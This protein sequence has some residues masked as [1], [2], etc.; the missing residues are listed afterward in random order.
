MHVK[1]AAQ[2]CPYTGLSLCL[3]HGGSSA[4]APSPQHPSERVSASVRVTTG[5]TAGC[6]CAGDAGPRRGRP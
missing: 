4:G 3:R 2:A 6:R 5:S 1:P